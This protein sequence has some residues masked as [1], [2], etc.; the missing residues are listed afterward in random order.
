MQPTAAVEV[1]VVVR[2]VE[3]QKHPVR[4]RVVSWKQ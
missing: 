1:E 3:E 4:L 2:C